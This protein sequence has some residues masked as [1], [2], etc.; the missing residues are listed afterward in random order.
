MPFWYC[1]CLCLLVLKSFLH[2]HQ[3]A[4]IPLLVATVI[5]AGVNVFTIGILVPINNRIASLNTEPPVP[6]W[7]KDHIKWDPLRR[8]RILLLAGTVLAATYSLVG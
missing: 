1:L 4:L 8:I 2:R 3:A 5:W 7:R 6:G